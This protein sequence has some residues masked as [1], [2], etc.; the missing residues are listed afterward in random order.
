MF[1]NVISAFDPESADFS[2]IFFRFDRLSFIG[3]ACELSWSEGF[4][5][6]MLYVLPA[7]IGRN[8]GPGN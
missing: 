8:T 1:T 6:P 3:A 5:R 4:E 7:E 2:T